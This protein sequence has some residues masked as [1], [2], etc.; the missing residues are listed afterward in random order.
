MSTDA[1][2]ANLARILTW[3]VRRFPDREALRF[4]GRTWTYAELDA[5]V[6]TAAAALRE[7]GLGLGDRVVVLG[8]NL[9][10]I[11]VLALGLARVG[12]VL[13]PL[14]V[15]LHDDELVALAQ[16]AKPVGLVAAPD[17]ADA[18]RAISAATPTLD[19]RVAIDGPIEV[20]GGGAAVGGASG[21]HA[22]PAAAFER[23]DDFVAPGAGQHVP[24]AVL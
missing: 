7:R 9:P 1:P 16:R 14:N 18:A 22:V 20:A 24:D 5:E 13:V 12:G 4:E 19:W 23:W 3:A 10:E 6:H 8:P 11:L 17:C 2:T 15:R 21:G